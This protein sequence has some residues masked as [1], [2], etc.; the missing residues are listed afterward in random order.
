M[1]D[2]ARCVAPSGTGG[3]R[4]GRQG[5]LPAESRAC[6]SVFACSSSASTSAFSSVRTAWTTGSSRA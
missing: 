3:V 6:A 5:A 4:V 1:P 2:D